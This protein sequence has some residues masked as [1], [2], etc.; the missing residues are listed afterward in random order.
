MRVKNGFFSPPTRNGKVACLRVMGVIK[1]RDNVMF[2]ERQGK[3]W[4]K[5][6]VWDMRDGGRG[7]REGL[8]PGRR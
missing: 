4:N 6:L 5:V 8:A 1:Y 2:W 7:K 3:W